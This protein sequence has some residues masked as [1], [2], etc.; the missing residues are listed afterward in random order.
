MSK[1]RAPT[2]FTRLLDRAAAITTTDLHSMWADQCRKGNISVPSG[3]P[4]ADSGDQPTVFISKSM[5]DRS[6]R[7]NGCTPRDALGAD[8]GA[9]QMVAE[10]GAQGQNPR[11][12]ISWCDRGAAYG[13]VGGSPSI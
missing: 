10:A 3:I 12:A 13:V 6:A 1:S 4:G 5:P 2:A 7:S 9:T 11:D 8:R